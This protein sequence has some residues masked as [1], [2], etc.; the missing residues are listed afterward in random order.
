MLRII[1]WRMAQFPLILAI[2]Y[3]ITFFFVWVAPGDPFTRSERKLD[4]IAA[5]ALKKRFHADKWYD[6]LA[7]YPR[8]ILPQ[9]DFAR[10]LRECG[11]AL[12]I[13]MVA[14]GLLW[15]AVGR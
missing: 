9:G 4:P 12:A 1:A 14:R 7:F 11:I 10:F 5:E 13:V 2:I 3:L 15:L 8:Q 6:F